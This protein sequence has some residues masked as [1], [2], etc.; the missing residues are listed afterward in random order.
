M[1]RWYLNLESVQLIILE[2]KSL[3]NVKV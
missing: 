3:T 1:G 2:I